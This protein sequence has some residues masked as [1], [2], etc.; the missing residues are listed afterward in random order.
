MAKLGARKDGSFKAVSTVPSINKTPVGGATPPLPYPVT[1]DLGSSV[2]IIANVNFN[3]DPVYV[4][5]SSKQPS[6]TGDEAGSAHGVKSGTTSGEVKPTQGSSTVRIGGK[7]VIRAGDP[8]TL[9]GGNCPGVYVTMQ[10]PSGTVF[11][12][13]PAASANPPVA[14]ETKEE[15]GFWQIA[16]PWVH[17][18]LGIASFVP[19]LSVITGGA[20]AAIYAGEGDLINAGLSAASMIPGGKIVTTAGKAV[21]GAAG[22]LKGAHAAEEA[23]KVGKAAH[24]AE[25]AAKAAKLA[26]EAEEAEA[27]EKSEKTGKENTPAQQ[28]KPDSAGNGKDGFKV[29]KQKS[30]PCDHL[31]QGKGKGPYRGGAHSKTSKPRNDQKDSHHMPTDDVSPLK[32]NEGPAIQMEPG[33]H[34][35]T[36]SNGNNGKQGNAYRK[37]IKA[38]LTNGE[39][40]KALSIEIKDVRRIAKETGEPRRYNEAMLEM[41]EYFRCL[42]KHDLLK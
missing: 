19:G 23:A 1:Q 7:P 14:P 21:K 31:R 42:E 41:L 35:S 27:L 36:T 9:N 22:L 13:S 34:R 32:T 40:R 33:D 4:L 24:E 8:C 5:N 26:K 18:A 25:E 12:G 29:K 39:W 20:D 10:A 6:C 11:Q 38:L 16:S 3:G 30:G 28:T 37:L 15:H 17:G 2:G